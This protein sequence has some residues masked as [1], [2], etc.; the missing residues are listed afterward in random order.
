MNYLAHAYLSFN[1]TGVL[2]GNMISDYVKGKKQFEFD[3]PIQKGIQLHRAIDAFTDAHDVTK[4][5]KEF[6]RPHY[7]LYAGAFCDVVYDYFLANDTNEF[8]NDDVL[9]NFAEQVYEQLYFDEAILPDNFKKMLPH[10]KTQNWL[11]NYSTYSGIEKSLAGL[12][13]RSKY[14]TESNTAFKILKENEIAMN[15]LYSQFFPEIK[16]YASVYLK[17]L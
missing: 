4:Q 11:Y 2:T 10:M 16:L 13:R 6:F 3:L 17:G 9:K 15:V 7:R 5:M 8:K 1:T 12:V 14:L